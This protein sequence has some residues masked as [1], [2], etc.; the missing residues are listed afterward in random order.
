MKALSPVHSTLKSR[1]SAHWGLLFKS[2]T[3][4]GLSLGLQSAH[5]NIGVRTEDGGV[6]F[7]LKT[8]AAGPCSINEN[9]LRLTRSGDL[10]AVG[11]NAPISQAYICVLLK[12]GVTQA[13]PSFDKSSD[14][15]VTFINPAGDNEWGFRYQNCIWV[16][17]PRPYTNKIALG[18]R[19]GMSNK[20]FFLG[21]HID[22]VV[23]NGGT[24]DMA[25]DLKVSASP[26]IL[27]YTYA[28]EQL[29]AFEGMIK[30]SDR[31]HLARLKLALTNTLKIMVDEKGTALLSVTDQAIT[32]N[33]RMI[34]VLS[35]VLNELLEEY[36]DTSND[37]MKIPVATLARLPKQIRDSYGW[38]DGLAGSGSKALASLA[39]VLDLELKDLYMAM[40]SFGTANPAAFN[41]ILRANARLSASVRANNGG[42]AAVRPALIE[43]VRAWNSQEWQDM[44]VQL[45]NAPQ[46]YQKLVQPKLKLLLMASESVSDLI[47]PRGT[48]GLQMKIS[49]GLAAKLK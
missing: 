5:A 31:R 45:M 13:L 22:A 32:E 26:M 12:P 44:L 6:Q 40:A 33:S 14:G 2:L 23:L 24:L 3:V 29:Q 4:L 1:L 8:C 38:K 35:T 17:L 37:W 48:D 9:L 18:H 49:D 19:R 7:D 25:N 36:D 21:F 11:A 34:M 20:E 16:N 39:T 47:D 46:D 30:K 10:S 41:N 27:T 28:L 42:D 15:K 43:V